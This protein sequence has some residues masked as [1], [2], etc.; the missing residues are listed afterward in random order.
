MNWTQTGEYLDTFGIWI[1]NLP[2][3]LKIGIGIIIVIL[4]FWFLMN[5]PRD[6]GNR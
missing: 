3:W 6:T 1:S 4:C 5:Q 2:L